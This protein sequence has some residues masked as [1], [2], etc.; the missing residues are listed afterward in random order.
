MKITNFQPHFFSLR[1]ATYLCACLTTFAFAR[2]AEH[3]FSLRTDLVSL[4]T[5]YSIEL[6]YVASRA[7]I[8][9]VFSR[10]EGD[11]RYG[12]SEQK[13]NINEFGIRTDF[14]F[15][16]RALQSAFYLG[17]G[18]LLQNGTQTTSATKTIDNE[19]CSIELVS[20]GTSYKTKLVLGRTWMSSIGFYS[21]IGIGGQYTIFDRDRHFEQ[22]SINCSTSLE[23]TDYHKKILPLAEIQFGWAL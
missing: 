5:G 8:G 2:G 14:Y 16:P 11:R 15:S 17:T 13:N 20:K 10:L 22:T 19:Y 18:V 6:N 1:L 4:N 3:G 7:L 23:S 21:S 9:V 12:A